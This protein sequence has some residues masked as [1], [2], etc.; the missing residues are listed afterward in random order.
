MSH[1]LIRAKVSS[2]QPVDETTKLFTLMPERDAAVFPPAFSPGSHIILHLQDDERTYRNPYSVISDPALTD[3]YEIAVRKEE[4]SRGGSILLHE[5]VAEGD[6]LGLEPPLNFFPLDKTGRKHVLVA[7]E[8]GITSPLSHA[9]Y[10]KEHEQPFELHYVFSSEDRAPFRQHVIDEYGDHVHLYPEGENE[11]LNEDVLKDVLNRQPLGSHLYV[12]SAEPEFADSAIEIARKSGWSESHLH[13]E[14][15]K[16]TDHESKP[17]T[18]VL[19]R[20]GKEVEVAAEFTLLEEL[21]NEGLDMPYMCRTGVC[22]E[23]EAE[24]IEG[25]PDHR[26]NYLDEK[27]KE[28]N[29]KIITCISRACGDKL[30]LDL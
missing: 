23:C 5:D 6:V 29:D 30:V 4:D 7:Y 1:E 10:L 11:F 12:C 24:L 9:R 2:I 27:E 25:E 22:G 26:D 28:A 19:A 18:A 8:I 16:S 20:S 3:R 15:F 13:W 17:F 21:E 14:V